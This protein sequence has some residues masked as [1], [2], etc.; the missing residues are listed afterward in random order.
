MP[1][2]LYGKGH[3]GPQ[4]VVFARLIQYCI[5]NTQYFTVNYNCTA[6]VQSR[7]MSLGTI[8][9]AQYAIVYNTTLLSMF[10]N[11][12]HASHSYS[13]VTKITS[14]SSDCYFK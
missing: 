12:A 3:F 6:S 9:Y 7:Q 8:Y 13:Y 4:L 1:Q 14:Y 5:T 11:E 10:R 2:S